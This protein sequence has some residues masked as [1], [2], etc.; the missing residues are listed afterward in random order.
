[1]IYGFCS[2]AA[3]QPSRL[4]LPPAGLA[5]WS[6][7]KMLRPTNELLQLQ[8]TAMDGRKRRRLMGRENGH[9]TRSDTSLIGQLTPGKHNVNM[10]YKKLTKNQE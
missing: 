6:Q 9:V 4:T 2:R 5:E 10:V 3:G 8:A 1:M 7:V